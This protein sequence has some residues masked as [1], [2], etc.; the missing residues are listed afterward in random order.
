[1]ERARRSKCRCC[2][3]LFRPDPRN[4]RYQR[5]CSKPSCRRASHVASQRRWLAKPQNRDY[6]RGPENVARVQAWRRDHPD[7]WR[8]RGANLASALQDDS[9]TQVIEV[10]SSSASLALQE[11]IS[12]QPL[13]LMG[14]IAHVIGSA[15]QDDIA[16]TSHR[17]LQLGQDILGGN[18]TRAVPA[19][20]VGR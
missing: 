11:I 14:L 20:R 12:A 18:A 17:L 13:V 8:Q 2:H 15:L 7:Y 3:E 9:R 19:P 1:M 5:Y 6:F 4:L 16:A 10:A